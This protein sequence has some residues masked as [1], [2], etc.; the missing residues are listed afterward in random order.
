MTPK[1]VKGKFDASGQKIAI[2]VSR[3]NH[4]LTDKLLDGALDCL[5]RHG[6]AES[7]IAVYH[8]PGAFEI[9]PTAAKLV[10]TKK[11][12]AIVCLGVVIR[13]ETPHF[14]YIAGESASGIARLALESDIPVI[15]GVVTTENLEQAIERCGSKAGNKG[16]DTALAAIEMINLGR[17]I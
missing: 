15:F 7:D 14:E 9:P 16:W 5:D 3:F 12:D 17:Q 13:G 8:V 2:V 11:F 6:A 10:K 1:T 4:F